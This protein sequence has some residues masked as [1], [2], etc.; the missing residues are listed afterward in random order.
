MKVPWLLAVEEGGGGE[1]RLPL[2][3]EQLTLRSF[4]SYPV[5]VS[6]HFKLLC[7]TASVPLLLISCIMSGIYMYINGF[8][9]L[10]N[11]KF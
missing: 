10:S 4:V 5:I 8:V 2:M 3:V 7:K 9:I 11:N 6:G 1:G